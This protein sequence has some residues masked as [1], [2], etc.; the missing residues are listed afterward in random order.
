MLRDPRRADLL[1]VDR[2][3]DNAF[4]GLLERQPAALLHVFAFDV[5]QQIE[6]PDAV[7]AVR[8]VGHAEK[9]RRRAANL[10]RRQPEALDQDRFGRRAVLARLAQHLFELPLR[11]PPVGDERVVARAQPPGRP[12]ALRKLCRERLRE[13]EQRLLVQVRKGLAVHGVAQLDN[14]L[15]LSGGRV[16]HRRREYPPRALAASLAGELVQLQPRRDRPELDL[17][18]NVADVHR[19]ARQRD[20]AGD[21]GLVDRQS[22]ARRRELS[23]AHARNERGAV[24]LD[25]EERELLGAEQRADVGREREHRFVDVPVRVDTRDQGPQRLEEREPRGH[26]TRRGNLLGPGA[27]GHYLSC[28]VRN[29]GVGRHPEYGEKRIDAIRFHSSAARGTGSPPAREALRPSGTRRANAIQ[30][31]RTWPCRSAAGWI[32]WLYAPTSRM[33]RS[34]CPGLRCVRNTFGAAVISSSIAASVD[35]Q[36]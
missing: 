13:R 1:R 20:V 29:R 10:S 17:V 31:S 34:T 12:A 33:M 7:L 18:V 3:H 21:A 14:R 2:E 35:G 23:G 9:A 4:V 11:H 15:H 27:L 25:G 24:L 32:R 8:L 5:A 36:R 6:L 19:A 28:L 22:Y 26:V 30:N 16:E